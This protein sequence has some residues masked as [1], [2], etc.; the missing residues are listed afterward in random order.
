MALNECILP[1][2]GWD[3]SPV[4]TGNSNI[5]DYISHC[6]QLG[7]FKD[8]NKI[9]ICKSIFPVLVKQ[10]IALESNSFLNSFKP[11]EGP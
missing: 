1:R 10:M 5:W 2:T 11:R 6:S 4:S 8:Y 7:L 9:Q 3:H